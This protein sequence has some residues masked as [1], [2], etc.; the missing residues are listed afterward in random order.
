[1]APRSVSV[2]RI[3]DRLRSALEMPH[4]RPPADVTAEDEAAFDRYAVD[5][6]AGYGVLGASFV[7]AVILVWWPVDRIVRPDGGYVEGFAFM[8]AW[9]FLIAAVTLGAFLGSSLVRRAALVAVPLCHATLLGW[10]GYSL[11]R[12][13]GGELSWLADAILGM[14]PAALLPLRLGPRVMAT[15]FIGLSLTLGFFLPF[16]EN[17]RAPAAMGQLSFVVF[18]ALTAVALGEVLYRVLRRSFLQQ[19]SIDRARGELAALNASLADRVAEQTRELRALAGHLDRAQ[20]TQRRRISRDLHDELSQELAA[21]R[22]TLAR[23]SER[24]GE[25]PESIGELVSD[26]SA[27]LDGTTE[28]VRGFLSE[29]RP[30]V[31]DDLGLL[32]AAEWLCERVRASGE[33]ECRLSV[34][35]DA[36]DLGRELDPEIALT[37]FRV[38]QEATTNARKHAGASVIEIS[39]AA[40]GAEI[41]VEVQDDGTGFDLSAPS[42]GFGLLGIRERVRSVGGRLALESS[43]GHGAR[44]VATV[45]ALREGAG[46]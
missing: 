42:P 29:L 35:G 44:V 32:A 11:G 9:G 15:S 12:M 1:M 39:V 38:L 33:V 2:R 27:L 36:G 22:Y 10:I 45:P 30:R 8:R 23:L 14:V 19:R 28:T 40:E 34:T 16:P 46:A 31:L 20:E 18:A 7:L 43:R 13:G 5:L 25:G 6:T 24:R 21:M 26:L 3:L 37:L 17:R 41:R 4:L